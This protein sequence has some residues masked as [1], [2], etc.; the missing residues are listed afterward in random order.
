MRTRRAAVALLPLALV[1]CGASAPV[2][3]AMPNQA[4]TP[5]VS[6]TVTP[7]PHVATTSAAPQHPRSLRLIGVADAQQVISVV[8]RGY[9]TTSATL[10]AF[11]RTSTGWHRV[12]GPWTARI[13]RN[14]FAPPRR[15]REGDGRTPTGSFRFQFMF[16]ISANPG[17]LFRYRRALTT[18]WWDDDPLSRY[19][20]QWVDSRYRSPGRSPESMHQT[21]AYDYGAVIAY[22]T[23]RTPGLGSAIF[24]HVSHIGPTAGCVSI[25]R[26][27]LLQILRWLRPAAAPRIIMGPASVVT[28]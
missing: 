13:G 19:Y 25:P 24:L 3:S 26:S 16:G 11:R 27:R 18:S 12:F 15:K 2:R 20:N 22:N 17:V 9:G 21:P 6:A 10:R 8:S 4:V 1:A 28:R 23:A 5:G 14:G 7:T